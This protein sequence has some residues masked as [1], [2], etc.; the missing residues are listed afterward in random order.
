MEQDFRAVLLHGFSQEEALTIMRAVKALGLQG[1]LPAFATST[2][3]N[4]GWS[5]SELF[6]HLE[7]EHRQMLAWREAQREKSSGKPAD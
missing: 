6:G 5:L 4:I 2:P 1:S 7:E 3:N